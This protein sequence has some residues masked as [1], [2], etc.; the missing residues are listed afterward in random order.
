MVNS[1]LTANI[2]VQDIDDKITDAA[3]TNFYINA[4]TS[5]VLSVQN[6][7]SE[8][9]TYYPIRWWL[10]K[11]DGKARLWVHFNMSFTGTIHL[12]IVSIINCQQVQLWY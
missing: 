7:L 9:C 12:Q 2:I 10:N 11:S 1:N 3:V 5:R 6:N 4:A 8:F